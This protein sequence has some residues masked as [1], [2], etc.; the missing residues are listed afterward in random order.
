MVPP[1]NGW[2]LSMSGSQRRPPKKQS[3]VPYAIRMGVCRTPI[4][5]GTAASMR[6]TMLQRKPL[7]G[8]AHNATHATNVLHEYNTSYVQ[9]SAKITKLEKSNKK[10][11]HTNKKC[12][13]DYDS[14]SDDSD[15][16]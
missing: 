1:I 15:S 11:K 4:T 2:S 6:R 3:T 12:K 8:S 5:P 9:L 10:L 7:Q 14:N 13:N 16:S